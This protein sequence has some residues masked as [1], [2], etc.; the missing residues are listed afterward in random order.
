M[1][2]FS[3]ILLTQ[4]S[5]SMCQYNSHRKTN[6][7]NSTY[8]LVTRCHLVKIEAVTLA[9]LQ[10]TWLVKTKSK[11]SPLTSRLQL[12][13]VKRVSITEINYTVIILDIWLVHRIE[14]KQEPCNHLDIT[15]EDGKIF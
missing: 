11:T 8:M 7:F 9:Q 15:M 4:C 13:E 2:Y 10:P 5:R 3:P 14:S 1:T 6:L 12:K